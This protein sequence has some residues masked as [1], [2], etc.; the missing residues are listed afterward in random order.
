[1]LNNNTSMKQHLYN[2]A[3]I[4][5]LEHCKKN[6]IDTSGTHVL[7]QPRKQHYQLTKENGEAVASITF[8]KHSTPSF[9]INQYPK[10]INDKFM[11][12]KPLSDKLKI[13]P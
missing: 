12:G 10:T 3:N 7:K 13:I 9:Y 1:M 6:N 5:L 8:H 4:M 11:Y 2:L